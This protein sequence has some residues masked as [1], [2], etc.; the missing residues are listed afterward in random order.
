MKK[1]QH[2]LGL[3]LL[4]L[5]LGGCGE[6]PAQEAAAA[7]HPAGGARKHLELR[8]DGDRATLSA[9]GLARAAAAQALAAGLG[10]SVIGAEPHAE[11]IDLAFSDQPAEAA[12]N[13]VAGPWPHAVQRR[14]D[15]RWELRFIA[16]M[17]GVGAAVAGVSAGPA[18]VERALPP[19][20]PGQ[21][22]MTE[23]LF[24]TDPVTGRQTTEVYSHPPS[25]ERNPPG[26]LPANALPGGAT[27]SGEDYFAA[28]PRR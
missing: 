16:D 6:R 24:V 4:A 21:P 26:Q 2:G 3:A 17:A 9:G 23:E 8:I 20:P 12:L 19:P 7:A 18:P 11:P 10:A 14:A 1:K 5:A 25:T 13:L 28:P 27:S 22:G 15:G